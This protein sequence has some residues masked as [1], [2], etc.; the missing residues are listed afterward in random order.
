MSPDTATA[1]LLIVGARRLQPRVLR[2]RPG[3][4]LSGHPA[5]G[6]RRD[7]AALRGG[8]LGP[9][10]ALAGA[11]PE[12]ARACCPWSR[13]W[14]WPS[15]RR[16][17]SPSWSSI[18]VGATASLVQALG[19]V[20]WPFAVPELARRYLAAPD[21]PEGEA[22]PSDGGGRVRHAPPAARRGHR[23]APGV[24]AHRRLDPPRRV[25]RSCR[26]P[27]CRRGSGSSASPSGSALL[28]GTLE[29]VGPNERDGWAL[30]GSDRAHRVHRV[31]GVADRARRLPPAVIAPAVPAFLL[32]ASV[33]IAAALLAA[34][35]RHTTVR[36]PAFGL[37]DVAGRHVSVLGALAGFAVTAIVLLV[38]QG[39][40]VLEPTGLAFTTV[41]AMFVVAYMGYFSSSVLYANVA[42]G[43]ED[44]PFDLAAAQY[45]GASISLFSV[46]LGWLALKPLFE[47]FGLVTIATLTGWLLAGVVVVGYSQ[48]A[49][50]LYRSGYASARL[51]VLL[52]V[53]ATAATLAY[54]LATSARAESPCARGHAPAHG[55][56][57]RGRASRLR[58]DDAPAGG[59]GTA[60]IGGHPRRPVAPG[61]RRLRPGRHGPGRL[62]AARR[63]GPRVSPAP[64]RPD[65]L[66]STG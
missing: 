5:Q 6:S 39:R 34:G 27:R 57:V 65:P 25:R 56:G 11:A 10:P 12:R 54:A 63:A 31:V 28:I 64:R 26:P 9:H 38:T 48:L 52:A 13:C 43:T 42:K 44:A 21:G 33:A 14:R 30:A 15:R 22:D 2:A 55:R 49:T 46:F 29:F 4:R 17:S 1:I 62:P 51:V 66:P 36:D 7:P 19:L 37:E 50:A 41:L 35:P 40:N 58:C 45:A 59:R 18:S 61:G 8:R 24:P 23:R 60:E 47:A 3:V 20:R 53:F 32:V 16:P